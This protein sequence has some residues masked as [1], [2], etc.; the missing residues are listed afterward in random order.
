MARKPK[1]KR[2]ARREKHPRLS[3]VK[4]FALGLIGLALGIG[5]WMV[6]GDKVPTRPS[7]NERAAF[8]HLLRQCSFGPRV[9]GTEAHKACLKYLTEELERHLPGVGHHRFVY[10][11]VVLKRKVEGT[12]IW[13]TSKPKKERF[14][15]SILL[16]AHWD[17]RPMADR[18]PN[19]ANRS[20]GVPGA[21]DGASGV[22]VL[23]EVA[24]VLARRPPPVDVHIVLFD[25][26]DM[27]GL[28]L[29]GLHQDPFCIGSGR[30]VAEHP[31][32]RPSFGVL[33][34]MVGKKD[35]R[36]PKEAISLER[37]ARVVD[38]I[39]SVARKLGMKGFVEEQGPAVYDDHVPF[40]EKGIPVVDLIDMEYAQWHTLQDTPER[41]SPQSLKQVGEVLLEMIYGN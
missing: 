32:F 38:R 41:C 14:P 22:A 6:L 40:L 24:R 30:F 13:A 10:E 3:W 2:N 11:S 39:W 4:P 21:N 31:E 19:P 7:F 28:P 15:G 33:L 18:D 23:L 20:K 36:I 5:L 37:A 12:N 8:E 29:G 17:S 1:I 27:G 25:M 16:C 26:E 34:D 35:L 9:P